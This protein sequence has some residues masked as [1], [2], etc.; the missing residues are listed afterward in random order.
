MPVAGAVVAAQVR[1]VAQHRRP[2]GEVR[3]L[4]LQRQRPRD[5]P[6]TL[7]VWSQKFTRKV[8]IFGSHHFVESEI[9]DPI[10]IHF[11]ALIP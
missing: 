10:Q 4:A 6:H 11:R 2:I 8:S 5:R 3:Q 1:P 7:S 9:F